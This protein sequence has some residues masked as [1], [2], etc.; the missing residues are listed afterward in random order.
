M[1]CLDP[2]P[3]AMSPRAL[4]TSDPVADEQAIEL[5]RIGLAEQAMQ[6]IQDRYGLRLFQFVRGLVREP[7]LA[8]D[9]VQEVLERVL[10]KHRLYQPG[11]NFRAWLFE[12]ARNQALSALRA[13][14]RL[15]RP[16]S[17]LSR[18]DHDHHGSLLDLVEARPADRALEE[19]ELMTAFATAVDELPERYRAVFNL[20]VRQGRPYQE[21]ADLLRLPTGTVAIR[22]MRARTRLFGSLEHHLD[23]MRRPPA[24]FQ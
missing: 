9:I 12:I 5:L 22:I 10:R 4:R 18:E 21:A 11:T 20:C 3:L 23:R 15:P 19:A 7:H 17:S 14:R 13:Q 24:C 6:S 8:Q 2:M 1:A 16:I